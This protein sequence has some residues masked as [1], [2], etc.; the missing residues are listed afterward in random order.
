MQAPADAIA[1]LHRIVAAGPAGQDE[2]FTLA[3]M[4]FLE[5]A[6]GN[7]SY[8]FATV[9]YACAFLFQPRRHCGPCIHSSC[10][11]A[12]ST[13]CRSRARW[14]HPMGS[15]LIR[16]QAI[17]PCL[18]LPVDHVRPGGLRWAD[19][20]LANYVPAAELRID[21]L[22]NRYRTNGIGAPAKADLMLDRDARGFQWRAVKV[23]VTA[24]CDRPHAG[25]FA[26]GRTGRS[27]VSGNDQRTVTIGGETVPLE[28]EPSAAFAYALS[29]G[30]L[31][32]RGHASAAACASLPA[33]HLPSNPIVW[34]DPV[35]LIHGTASS[36]GR[37]AVLHR[38][39]E[40]PGDKRPLPVLVVHLR[41]RGS[42]TVGSEAAHRS[43]G[44]GPQ[45]D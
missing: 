20:S 41:Y 31:E 21:G 9:I 26:S 45:V 40:R 13:I 34:P 5:G 18:R 43:R 30:H 44:C 28:N 36:A 42:G 3:E 8:S 39:A 1:A 37:W 10:A 11:P 27:P 16:V 32:E 17:T 12:G 24:L 15:M 38:P 35:V 23:P 19:R 4:A 33:R 2:L 29:N 25:A 14:H 6:P 7:R 22:H